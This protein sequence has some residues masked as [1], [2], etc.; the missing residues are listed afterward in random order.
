MCRYKIYILKYN[1]YKYF[2]DEVC[3]LS[4]YLMRG[5]LLLLMNI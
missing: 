3:T 1:E 4:W 5:Y 2:Y